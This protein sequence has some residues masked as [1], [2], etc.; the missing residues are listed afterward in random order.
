M[1]QPARHLASSYRSNV[2]RY[3]YQYTRHAL[4]DN[5]EQPGPGVAARCRNHTEVCR[6]GPCHDYLMFDQPAAAVQSLNRGRSSPTRILHGRKSSAGCR[7]RSL[8][9][10]MRHW[11]GCG[12]EH[13]IS[14][15][16]ASGQIC[17][18]EV[19]GATRSSS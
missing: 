1:S 6:S 16:S 12:D 3:A 14:R 10:H 11:R 15:R 17:Q 5:K 2:L 19:R 13:Y 7:P 4:R 9:Q 18:R 8:S